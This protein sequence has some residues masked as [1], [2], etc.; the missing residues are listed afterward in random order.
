MRKVLVAANVILTFAVCFALANKRTALAQ[1]RKPIPVPDAPNEMAFQSLRGVQYCEV[2]LF[3]PNAEKGVD[4]NYYNTSALNNGA[5]KKDTC[6]SNLWSK[7]NTEELKGQ[8]QIGMAFKNGPRGWTMDVIELP[9]GP[10][11]DFNGLKARW[12]GKGVLP[13]GAPPMKPGEMGYKPVQSHRKSSM[14]FQ[15]GQPVFILDDPEGTP[16]V[17]QAYSMIVDTTITYD[18]LN[19]LG[20]KLKLPAGW[21]SVLLCWTRT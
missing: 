21:K 11:V 18:S 13:A 8:Y 10:V 20:D 5:N 12:F 3:V 9:V 7:I 15:K 17:M 4:I 16:W 14:T 2:L 6:P 1:D 19:K